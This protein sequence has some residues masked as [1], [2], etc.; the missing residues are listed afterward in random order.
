M[1]QR[2]L[3]NIPLARTSDSGSPGP[4]WDVGTVGSV[5]QVGRY[6]HNLFEDHFK[7]SC[8]LHTVIA[9]ELHW[10]CHSALVIITVVDKE[11]TTFTDLLLRGI[12]RYNQVQNNSN[13]IQPKVT[14][15]K[16]RSDF[17]QKSA[18]ESPRF[19][20]SWPNTNPAGEKSVGGASP[21]LEEKRTECPVTHLASLWYILQNF[22]C[23]SIE[24]RGRN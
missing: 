1:I 22:Y 6:L 8:T 3:T 16:R 24:A 2:S 5:D 19:V 14:S 20:E 23:T 9:W 10:W 12:E 7:W 18:K 11:R 15:A 17:S 13:K 4:G 21:G